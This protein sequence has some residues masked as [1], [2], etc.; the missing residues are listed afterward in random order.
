MERPPED[1]ALEPHLISLPQHLLH[2]ILCRAGTGAAAAACCCTTLRHAWSHVLIDPAHACAIL[3]ER[4]ASAETVAKHLYPPYSQGGVQGLEAF[5]LD[6]SRS[7]KAS[8]ALECIFTSSS[9]TATTCQSATTDTTALPAF[10]EAPS[11]VSRSLVHNDA[12]ADAEDRYVLDVVRNLEAQFSD[13]ILPSEISKVVCFAAALAGHERVVLHLL[14]RVKPVA[15]LRGAAMAGNVRLCTALMPAFEI[16]FRVLV[17][18]EKG[19]PWRLVAGASAGAEGVVGEGSEAEAVD[20][21]VRAMCVEL[22]EGLLD[23]A[24]T[25]A[26]STPYGQDCGADVAD[27]G[28][29]PGGVAGVGSSSSSSGAAGHAAGGGD[30]GGGIVKVSAASSSSFSSSSGDN[31]SSALCCS[32]HDIRSVTAAA[33]AAAA[34]ARAAA[35]SSLAA[36]GPYPGEAAHRVAV[37]AAAAALLAQSAMPPAATHAVATAASGCTATDAAKAH[38]PRGPLS[39]SAHASSAPPSPPCASNPQQAH[40]YTTGSSSSADGSPTGGD[41]ASSG[42]TYPAP[43]TSFLD[44][45]H[46]R[47]AQGSPAHGQALTPPP[48]ANYLALARLLIHVWGADLRCDNNL[49]LETAVC[50]AG[51]GAMAAELIRAGA[52]PRVFRDKPLALAQVAANGR[53]D[54]V[55][56][57]LSA[58]GLPPRVALVMLGLLWVQC[59]LLWV[60]H[61]WGL[62]A[63]SGFVAVVVRWLWVCATAPM[64]VAWSILWLALWWAWG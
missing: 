18:A 35:A 50:T 16:F 42:G 37:A 36:A 14:P 34:A 3:L 20:Q 7:R 47:A 45:P 57:V 64:Q 26:P 23:L 46:A 58:C 32:D 6:Q 60:V 13:E 41:S 17:T 33:A 54:L 21:E 9:I 61:M 38:S 40:V 48:T 5:V 4:Y 19:L 28:C 59:T 1:F 31:S 44:S 25:C 62:S 8:G 15:A 39:P 53:W 27:Q 24:C 56:G 22:A 2:M 52:D 63:G 43:S 55:N 11:R 30:A 10:P 51:S 29:T 49:A 12:R